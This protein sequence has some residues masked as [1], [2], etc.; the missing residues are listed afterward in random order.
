MFKKFLTRRHWEIPRV[1]VLPG[2]LGVV[3]MDGFPPDVPEARQA[4]AD[5]MAF[6]DAP[7]GV[8]LPERVRSR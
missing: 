2:N 5:A 8:K 6:L 4:I 1:E 7:G 3:K